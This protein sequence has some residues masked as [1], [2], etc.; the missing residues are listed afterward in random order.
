M[1]KYIVLICS[2]LFMTSCATPPLVEQEVIWEEYF[3]SASAQAFVDPQAQH[4]DIAG[5]GLRRSLILINYI[6]ADTEGTHSAIMS[7]ALDCNNEMVKLESFTSYNQLYGQ[8]AVIK[9][10]NVPEEGFLPLDSFLNGDKI[11][12]IVCFNGLE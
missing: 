5:V 8:G 4:L 10:N 6:K 2:I 7:F 9:N 12:S 3:N 1:N 11:H